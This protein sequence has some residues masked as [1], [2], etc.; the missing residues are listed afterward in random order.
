M[1]PTILVAGV[2]HH[3]EWLE[4]VGRVQRAPWDVLAPRAAASPA[5][6][7]VVGR[8]SGG[9]AAEA[10]I[11][12]LK[13]DPSTSAIPVL[14]AAPP[15]DACAECRADVCLSAGSSPGQLARVAD[16]LLELARALARRSGLSAARASL[17]GGAVSRPAP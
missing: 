17:A 10:V 9:L 13:D 6:L 7:I 8:P 15:G 2:V 3:L 12:A 16:A 1:P 4:G 11:A 14:H 5:D